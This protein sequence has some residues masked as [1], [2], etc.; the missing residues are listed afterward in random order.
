MTV[1]KPFH[2]PTSVYNLHYHVVWV[3]KYRKHVLSKQIREDLKQMI[4]KIMQDNDCKIEALEIMPN[5]VHMLMAVPPKVS[6]TGLVK[7]LKGTTARKLYLKYPNLRYSLWHGHLWSKSYYIGS[8][9][10]VNE[11]TVKHYINTQ[12]ERPYK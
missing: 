8:I 12:W 1:C 2:G 6:L 11:D 10:V 7:Q 9:G 4:N 3:T 5:H